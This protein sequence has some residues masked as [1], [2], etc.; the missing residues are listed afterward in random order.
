MRLLHFSDTHLWAWNFQNWRDD[1]FYNNFKKV[2]DCAL[3][4]KPDFILHSWDLFHYSK[5]SNKALSI[6]MEGFL[7]LS[8]AWIKTLILAWNHSTP[9]WEMTVHP[10]DI[11]KKLDNFELIKS[12]KIENFEYW[13][14][15]FVCLSHQ[16]DIENFTNQLKTA[17]NFIKKEKINIFSS[18]FWIKNTSYKN[19]TDE[20]SWVDVDQENLLKLEDFDYV[21]LWHY[22]KNFCFWKKKNLCYSW[23]TE[24]TSFSQ[25]DYKCWFNIIKF[26]ENWEFEKE[27][28]QL[29]T[30][31]MTKLEINCEIFKNTNELLEDIKSRKIETKW[32]II[33]IILQNITKEFWINFEDK[34]FKKYFENTLEL[35]YIKEKKQEEWIK[36]NINIEEK[37]NFVKSYFS[38]FIKQKNIDKSI[39]KNKIEK[40]ILDDLKKL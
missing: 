38:D 30:R 26:K 34:I 12:D 5:P 24:K 2:I 15:N 14:I 7:S 29:E 3:K 16:N 28:V 39:D 33:H 36:I 19:Y 18:H 17:P 31:K 37:D 10:F 11:F 25:K 13:N 27:F 4:I 40:E 6:A 32:V 35:R 8:K 20:I 1:D 21:W 9:R 22:H 23:S